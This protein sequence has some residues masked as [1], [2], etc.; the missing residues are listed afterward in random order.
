MVARA[1][2]TAKEPRE[3]REAQAHFIESREAHA[4]ISR[5]E[6]GPWNPG[7]TA[8]AVVRVLHPLYGA[9]YI[10][11]WMSRQVTITT[12]LSF[13]ACLNSALVSTS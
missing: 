1:R 13:N 5:R 6:M 3:L 8:V 12:L 7:V 9:G 11:F 10:A 2:S 4:P